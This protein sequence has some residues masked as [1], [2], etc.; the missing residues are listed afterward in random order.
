MLSEIKAIQSARRRLSAL[1]AG[2][3]YPL[4]EPSCVTPSV[5]NLTEEESCVCVCVCVC[6]SVCVCVCVGVCALLNS[7]PPYE[8][9]KHVENII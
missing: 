8:Y 4:Y 9:R 6:L 7:P 5:G 2:K 3:I 1:L